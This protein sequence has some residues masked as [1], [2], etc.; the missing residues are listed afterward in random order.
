MDLTKRPKLAGAIA[1]LNYH[2]ESQ[3]LPTFVFDSYI[4]EQTFHDFAA[5]FEEHE[6]KPMVRLFFDC[7]GGWGI[8]HLLSQIVDM[9][10]GKTVAVIAK[11]HSAATLIA[12]ACDFRIGVSDAKML[13][14]KSQ[15]ESGKP[16]DYEIEVESM[17]RA[18]RIAKR[19]GANVT[20]QQVF[21]WMKAEKV[22]NV[23][24]ME[25]FGLID[26]IESRFSGDDEGSKFYAQYYCMETQWAVGVPY[27]LADRHRE[28]AF[29][30]PPSMAKKYI[31]EMRESI[32]AGAPR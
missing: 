23:S 9:F 26:W 4:S 8:D 21:G 15:Y 30:C 13:F 5:F 2:K 29:H 1:R 18:K 12:A 25:S 19:A 27:M 3:R 22:L 17:K 20:T 6:S 14:H 7:I 28:S 31:V 16:A 11:A 24:E 10:Q 32:K